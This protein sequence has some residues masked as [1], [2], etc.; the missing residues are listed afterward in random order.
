MFFGGS[1]GFWAAEHH[2]K[3]AP[4]RKEK[5]R[6]FRLGAEKYDFRAPKEQRPKTL[7]VRR[8]CLANHGPPKM[9]RSNSSVLFQC[10]LPAKISA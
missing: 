3:A 7:V 4:K 9:V 6:F 10:P 8:R 2:N 1:K 5:S